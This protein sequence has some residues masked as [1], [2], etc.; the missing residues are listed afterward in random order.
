MELYVVLAALMQKKVIMKKHTIDFIAEF[1]VSWGSVYFFFGCMR[2]P[3]LLMH[4]KCG[5]FDLIDWIY[6]RKK[7][8]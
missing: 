4:K 3:Y 1:F 6:E 8:V 7:T 5:T 2:P